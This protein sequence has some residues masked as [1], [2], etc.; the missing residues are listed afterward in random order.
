MIYEAPPSP[1][2]ESLFR[3]VG[4]LIICA[5]NARLMAEVHVRIYIFLVRGYVAIG[6]ISRRLRLVDQELSPQCFPFVLPLFIE[7]VCA[8][9]AL[10]KLE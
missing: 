3:G 8:E 9:C 10:D 2:A 4:V 1:A 7:G 6:G 5:T